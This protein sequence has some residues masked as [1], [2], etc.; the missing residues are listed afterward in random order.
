MTSCQPVGL[1]QYLLCVV[2][3]TAMTDVGFGDR[4]A[5]VGIDDAR[6]LLGRI[7]AEDVAGS[8]MQPDVTEVGR[9]EHEILVVEEQAHR[10]GSVVAFPLDLLVREEGDIRI[11]I[12]EQRDQP[13]GHAA[14]EPAAVLLLEL[15]RIGEPA[16]GVAERADRELDQHLAVGRRVFVREHALALL[17]G[18]DPEAHVV[19]LG[20]VDAAA[21]E[22]GLE[23]D[24]AGVEIAEPHPPW[25]SAPPAAPRGTRR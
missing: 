16:D 25:V 21:L 14:G 10:I 12:A 19:A 7:D 2:L 6:R 17:P 3:C 24:I 20:A 18:L 22:L 4:T 8:A 1:F 15:H 23:Q 5:V 11:G 13:L 9:L